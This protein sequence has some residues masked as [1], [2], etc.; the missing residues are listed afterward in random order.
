M[1]C[2]YQ[3]TSP[4]GKSYIGISSK[5]AADR[6]VKHMEHARGKRKNGIIYS[7]LRKYGPDSF[8]VKTLVIANDFQYLCDLEVKVIAAFGT[9]YPNGYNMTDGGEGVVGPKGDDFPMKVSIAQKKRF[10]RPEER[11]KAR[12]AARKGTLV[13]MA[14]NAAKRVDGLA[15]WQQRKRAAA[16]RQSSPEHR[17]KLSAATKA[18]M[19]TPEVKENMIT[20]NKLRAL[21]NRSNV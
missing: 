14:Q 7:A 12:I 16:T 19:A 11:E 17:A 20:G 8:D 3:L 6:F 1:G 21:R 13:R 9:K 18:A 2:L 5:T 10:E 15:P 4:S